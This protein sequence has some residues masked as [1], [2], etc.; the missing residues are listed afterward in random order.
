MMKKKW[1]ILAMVLIVPAMLFTVS[2]AKKTVSSEP[3][4]TDTATTDTS[5]ADMDRQAELDR[6][7]QLEEER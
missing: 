1:I 4:T 3:S 6:Q 7:K 2:C 5:Q